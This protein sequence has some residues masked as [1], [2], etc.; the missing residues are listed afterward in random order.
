MPP[1]TPPASGLWPRLGYAIRAL[2]NYGFKVGGVLALLL[3]AVCLFFP[4]TVQSARERLRDWWHEA[5][6]QRDLEIQ[7]QAI[8]L[9]N[10]G[11]F[12]AALEKYDLLIDRRKSDLSP[13]FI[14]SR[15]ELRSRVGRYDDALADLNA[16]IKLL[17][18]RTEL[19]LQRAKL[20]GQRED[21]TS[22]LAECDRLLERLTAKEQP[23]TDEIILLYQVRQYHALMLGHLKKFDQ[24][25]A[26]L[27]PLIDRVS[28]DRVNH[29]YLAEIRESAGNYRGALEEYERA[30]D[31]RDPNL[32]HEDDMQ[33]WAAVAAALAD[34]LATCPDDELRDGSRAKEIAQTA[35]QRSGER[36]LDCGFALAAAHAELGEFAD[37]VRVQERTIGPLAEDVN[38]EMQRQRLEAFRQGKPWRRPDQR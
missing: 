1:E 25:V 38:L 31:L 37:A 26:E 16:L 17:P 28:A 32:L 33:T 21:W 3:L 22:A 12:A 13:V 2:A 27:Q 35:R 7:K 36:I 29:L 5:A 20:Y 24:A 10:N 18:A 23:T 14:E 4:G 8:D 15:T 6:L 30:Y 34:F 9:E 11:Q 19:L